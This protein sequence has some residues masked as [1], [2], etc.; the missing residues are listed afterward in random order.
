MWVGWTNGFWFWFNDDIC[1]KLKL[2]YSSVVV[3]FCEITIDDKMVIRIRNLGNGEIG[4][5]MLMLMSE[6]EVEKSFWPLKSVAKE[7]LKG[8][9]LNKYHDE[10]GA[11]WWIKNSGS[12]LIL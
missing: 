2:K 5:V 7:P 10:N 3:I 12:F 11:C 4:V 8:N 1:S 9:N 6:F